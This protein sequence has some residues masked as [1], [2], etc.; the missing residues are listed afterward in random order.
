MNQPVERSRRKLPQEAGSEEAFS[1]KTICLWRSLLKQTPHSAAT[2]ISLPIGLLKDR[3]DLSR[4]LRR[5][6][7]G[8]SSTGQISTASQGFVLIPSHHSVPQGFGP[9]GSTEPD[10]VTGRGLNMHHARAPIILISRRSSTQK[11]GCSELPEQPYV[12]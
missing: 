5:I 11:K 8:I 3:R 7:R 12:C 4:K 10:K 9:S 1:G 6:A 2:V